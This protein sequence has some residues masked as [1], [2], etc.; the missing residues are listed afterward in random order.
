[1]DEQY[2][3]PVPGRPARPWDLITQEHASDDIQE[4][5]IA[6]CEACEHYM[7]TKQCAKCFCFMP[8]KVKIKGAFCPIGK[9]SPDGH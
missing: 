7:A 4:A 5:R 9:W 1:M 2:G 8:L 6:L 3:P